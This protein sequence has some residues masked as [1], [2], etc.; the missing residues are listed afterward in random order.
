MEELSFLGICAIVH[1]A[2]NVSPPFI[3]KK[4][5]KKT[6]NDGKAKLGLLRLFLF[7]HLL[8]LPAIV[9]VVVAVIVVI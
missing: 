7:L 2:C 4:R 5:V 3:T 1:C 8:H 9:V 6:Q